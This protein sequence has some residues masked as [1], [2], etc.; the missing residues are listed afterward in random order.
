M[1]D[2]VCW[3]C[4]RTLEEIPLPISRHATCADC[5]NALHCCRMCRHFMKSRPGQCDHDLADPPLIKENANFCE[6]FRP[7]HGVFESEKKTR[8]DAARD[9][10][11]ALFDGAEE[12][13]EDATGTS[14]ADDPDDPLKRLNDLFED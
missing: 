9:R 4:G 11:A 7:A 2:L 14:A 10:F 12:K 3:N 8:Q 6:Y 1:A 13:L 5:F